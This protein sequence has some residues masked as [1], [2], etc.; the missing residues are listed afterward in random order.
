MHI[1]VGVFG[2]QELAARMGKK[3]TVNDI[4]FYSVSSSEGIFS[5]I[6]PASAKIQPFLQ[7]LNMIDFPVLVIKE[8]NKEAGE[9]IIGIDEMKFDR[10]FIIT[11]MKD[12]VSQ[13]VKGTSL[14]KFEFIDEPS[15]RAKLLEIKIE[16][17]NET[18][19]IPVDNYFNVKGI[20]AVVLA[21]VKSGTVHIHDKL[22]LEPLGKE[23]IIKGIQ[24][25][26]KDIDLAEPGTRVGLNLKGVEADDIKRGYVLCKSI[27]KL[28]LFRI[29]FAKSKFFKQELKPGINV[30]LSIGL[31]TVACNVES[32]GDELVLKAQQPMAYTKGDRCIVASQNEIMP[33]IIGSGI[34]L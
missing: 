8:F 16:R 34:I 31:Q 3:D 30:F 18:L 4:A 28:S 22:M 33:R 6:A 13:F 23:V 2:D 17:S 20:G 32:V 7:V 27:E 1:N 9:M 12:A 5:Y 24:S 15:L 19:M 21:I 29:K 10:G 14:E 26:D 25:H 11:E